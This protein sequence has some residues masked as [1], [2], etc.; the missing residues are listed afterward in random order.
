MA[1][2]ATGTNLQLN[3]S[4]KVSEDLIEPLA[5]LYCFNSEMKYSTTMSLS[6]TG[7]VLANGYEIHVIRS[8]ACYYSNTGAVEVY[9][10]DLSQQ[11][12][13]QRG[14]IIIDKGSHTSLSADGNILVT[15]QYQ[16][17]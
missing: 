1:I 2:S 3:R 5:D 13:H 4:W 7:K 8:E 16:G 14:S 12:W 17:K 11:A 6:E 15:G 10:W 9:L